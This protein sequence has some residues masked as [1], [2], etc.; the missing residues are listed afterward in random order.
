MKTN[1]CE[2]F[3]FGE[4]QQ[5]LSFVGA[6]KS[7]DACLLG[8]EEKPLSMFVGENSSGL[9][10]SEKWKQML[11]PFCGTHHCSFFFVWK[12]T[13]ILRYWCIL[14]IV[15]CILGCDWDGYDISDLEYLQ[16]RSP[17]RFGK[18]CLHQALGCCVSE[19]GTALYLHFWVLLAR[20]IFSYS[21]NQHRLHMFLHCFAL[22]R[23]PTSHF[24]SYLHECDPAANCTISLPPTT[25]HVKPNSQ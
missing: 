22:P 14:M 10:N 21:S 24:A 4:Q 8:V 25:H 3:Y 20:L 11:Y 7:G 2:P 15:R 18:Q 6:T 13:L 5:S 23:F 16:L 17:A 1:Q 12:L 19:K 9:S